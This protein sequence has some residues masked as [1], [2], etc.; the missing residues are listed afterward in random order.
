MF[1]FKKIYIPCYNLW[2][3]V[4]TATHTLQG[5]TVGPQIGFQASLFEENKHTTDL[6]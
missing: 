4:E 2:G 5:S 3:A 6:I 1:K